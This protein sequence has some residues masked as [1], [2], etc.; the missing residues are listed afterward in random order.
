MTCVTV[1]EHLLKEI[2]VVN[3]C[4]RFFC[5]IVIFPTSINFCVLMVGIPNSA[6][7][8]R[9]SI[10]VFFLYIRKSFS[11]LNVACPLF[12]YDSTNI[13]C[14]ERLALRNRHR[15][16]DLLQKH[17]TGT[18]VLISFVFGV[19]LFLHQLSLL[20]LRLTLTPTRC[21]TLGWSVNWT[22]D[23]RETLLDVIH[24]RRT[25][26]RIHTIA[27]YSTRPA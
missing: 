9:L 21:V 23:L 17:H 25:T 26:R 4:H 5:F 7:V 24:S 19:C 12:I 1:A 16:S 10:A 6:S 15:D 2:N 18:V 3:R 20:T 27:Y 14:V 8:F 11:C 22:S 13:Y